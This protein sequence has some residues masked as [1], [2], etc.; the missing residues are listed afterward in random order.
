MQDWYYDREQ[1]RAKHEILRRYLTPFAQKILRQW[2]SIDFIDGF[3]GPWENRDEENL[4]DTSIGVS[5]QTLS[6]VAESLGHNTS[7]RLIR[8]IFNEEKSSSFAKLETYLNDNREEFPLLKTA[9]F[10]GKFEDNAVEIRRS[11]THA[12]QLLFIDPTGYTGFPP[13]SLGL[14][15]GR[16][17]EIIVNFMRSFIERFVSGEHEDRE[18]HLA[19]LVGQ[20]RAKYLLVTGLT[21]ESLEAE[22][23]S[24]LRSDLGYR[25]AGFSPIHN[26][27]KN[28]IHFNLAYATNHFAG[29]EV[30]R[31]AEYG[32]LSEY[33]RKRF[34]RSRD[35]T[36][37]DL[38]EGMDEELEVRGP[39]LQRRRA[40]LDGVDQA[41]QKELAKHPNGID[42][43]NLAATVQQSHFLRQTE[44][45]AALV[46][47]ADRGVVQPAWRERSRK[48]PSVRDVIQLT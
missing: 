2:P 41:L 31:N 47:M 20:K 46:E 29:M 37:S 26:K 39:Y 3:S 23:L 42:F 44:L 13:S 4:S 25:F 9:I 34:E 45:K 33:D 18:R 14:F 40:H 19:G 30:L 10:R 12:F 7:N 5:L 24:M 22:Y 1:S 21:I 35:T 48:K 43:G 36:T 27:D 8:C 16:S 17:T 28:E 32:A 11:A 15:K 38:F 6:A